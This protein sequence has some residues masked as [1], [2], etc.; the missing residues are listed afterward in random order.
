VGRLRNSYQSDD[1][2]A[3]AAFVAEMT[4]AVQPDVL[5]DLGCNSGDYSKVALENGARRVVGFDFD[6][7]ALELAYD[8]AKKEDLAFLPLWLD[9]ANPSPSQGWAQGERKGFADRAGADAI[10]ALAFIHHIAIGRNVPLDMATH[11]L[12][13]LAPKG[14]IEF[15]HKA[16]PMVQTLL[17][18]RTDIFPDYENDRF[19]ALLGERARIVKRVDVLPTRT[20]YWYER[21]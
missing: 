13:S 11:W 4:A 18:Q 8:R 15:P 17:A 9:A 14:V 7:A 2:R 6:H 5:F 10:V 19:A 21:G 20:L 16:D 1:A 12:V 3:K